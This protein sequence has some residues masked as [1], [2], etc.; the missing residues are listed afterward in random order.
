MSVS[1]AASSSL[2]KSLVFWARSLRWTRESRWW[3]TR[4][5]AAVSR[6][7]IRAVRSISSYAVS[8]GVCARGARTYSAMLL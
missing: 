7:G 3:A 2:R 1:L 4:S 5:E 8:G 6:V